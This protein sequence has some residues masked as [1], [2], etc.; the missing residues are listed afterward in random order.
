MKLSAHAPLLLLSVFASNCAAFSSDYGGKKFY[1]TGII[2]GGV[3]RPLVDTA[4]VILDIGS[5]IT[6]SGMCAGTLTGTCT[7]DEGLLKCQEPSFQSSGCAGTGALAD[8]DLDA[9]EQFVVLV[10]KSSPE[11]VAV[12]CDGKLAF[13]ISLN[14]GDTSISFV[15]EGESCPEPENDPDEFDEFASSSI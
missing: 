9:Q 2:E 1:A 6:L 11:V 8:E 15:E 3:D 5:S 7:T 14:D 12:E 13:D 4:D 10:L